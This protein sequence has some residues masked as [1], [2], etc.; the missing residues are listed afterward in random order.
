MTLLDITMSS[1]VT[2]KCNC[3]TYKLMSIYLEKHVLC[4]LQLT[5][6]KEP[7]SKLRCY[8]SQNTYHCYTVGQEQFAPS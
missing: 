4:L 6:S 2:R 5:G 7:R 8:V 1:V 3:N